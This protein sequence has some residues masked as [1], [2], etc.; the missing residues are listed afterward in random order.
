MSIVCVGTTALKD[1]FSGIVRRENIRAEEI[2]RVEVQQSMRPGDVI[3][4]EVRTSLGS[5][6]DA[7]L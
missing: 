2:D 7:V 1:R 3:K 5:R 6:L 4:A